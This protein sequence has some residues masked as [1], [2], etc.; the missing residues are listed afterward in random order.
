MIVLN[1]ASYSKIFS[2]FPPLAPFRSCCWTLSC[3]QHFTSNP[4]ASCRCWGTVVV[5]CDPLNGSS[6]IFPTSL[7]TT[8]SWESQ[9]FLRWWSA[10]WAPS[11]LQ[12]LDDEETFFIPVD[13]ALQKYLFKLSIHASSEM[14]HTAA[15]RIRQGHIF[16]LNKVEQAMS[17]LLA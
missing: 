13:L 7:R 16:T 2:T 6:P 1:V 12:K 17:S 4:F 10:F 11:Y 14:T 9:V 8:W 3:R 5:W 15:S